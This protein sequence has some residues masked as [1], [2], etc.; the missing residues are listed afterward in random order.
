VLKRHELSNCHREAVELTITIPAT[1]TNVMELMQHNQ[2]KEKENNRGMLLKIVSSIRYLARQGLPLRGDG[3]EEDGNFLQLLQLKGE[4]DAGLLE[5]MKRKVNRYTS[6]DIQNEVLKVMATNILRTVSKCLQE[7][8]FIALML[9]ETTDIGND[10]QTT[11]VLRRVT[12]SF[13]VHEEFVGLYKVPSIDAATLTSVAKDALCR[14]NVPL[15]KLRGQCYDGASSMRGARSGVAKRIME[16]E[17]RAVYIHCYGHS[18]NL[19]VNDAIKLSLPIR[20]ALE[21]TYEVTKLIK[22][23]PKREGVFRELKSSHDLNVGSRSPGIRLLC[24]TRWTVRAD[25]LASILDNYETLLST[26]EECLQ[27]VRDTESKARIN[28]VCS[29]MK[30][31]DFMFGA[32]LGEMILRHSDNLSKTLQHKATS[33]AE[34]QVIAKM[35]IETIAKVRTEFDLFWDKLLKKARSV[36]IEE[37]QLPRRRRVPRCLDD[38][39]SSSHFHHES[40]KAYYR[41]VYYEAIDNTISCLSDRFNQPGY[42]LYSNLEQLL[43]KASQQEDFSEPFKTVCDFYKD[44]LVSDLLHVQLRTF[45]IDFQS[46]AMQEEGAI[47]RHPTIFDI[48]A[49]F[50]GLSGSQRSL[51]SQVSRVVQLIM[52]MPATNAS[53]ERSFSALRRVKTYL[54]STMG[55]QRLNNLMVLHVHKELTDALNLEEVVND[56]VADSEHRIRIF[57]KF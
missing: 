37:P 39:N 44:D 57:G 20:K 22:Y 23:S 48:R 8:P 40:P 9:D 15:S 19:A 13:D 10:E 33:A 52:V 49:Y 16:D 31:F 34:G 21:V 26:W 35:V 36:D 7:S 24:P 1:T 3:S 2:V 4:D 41:Q 51:L 28:G 18:I 50:Q 5:W 46:A 27:L 54:R 11:I 12:D 47:R 55:Q 30:T 6:H 29:Q 17:P 42:Q 56:F 53:S 25:A 45:G 14:L 38:G 32:V 43:I